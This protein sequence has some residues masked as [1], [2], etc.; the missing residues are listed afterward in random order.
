MKVS[1]IVPI[2]NTEKY[3]DQCIESIVSQEYA[4]LEILLINDGSTDRSGNI[5]RKWEALDARVRYVEKEN[6]GQG[7]ARNLG[8]RLAAGEYIIFVD[9]DDY[10][11]REL[12][13]RVL[14]RITE[15][16][17]DIC[18]YASNG[19]GD[20]VSK[21]MLEY[22]LVE[23][24]CVK[25][26]KELLGR[27]TPILWDKMFSTAFL[28]NAD[29]AMSN[30]IC[31]DLVYNARLC[32][33]A[34]KICFLDSPLYNYRYLRE[35]NFSTNYQ[36]YFEVEES[37][38][39]LNEIFQREGNFEEYWLQ[40]Y[41]I[42]FTMFKDILFRIRVKKEYHAPAEIK[43]RYPNFF[44][45]YK[46]FLSR[47]F[48]RYLTMEFQEKNFLLAG[49]YSLRVIVH[50]MLLD[51]EFL[52]A[53]YAAGSLVSMMSDSYEEAAFGEAIDSKVSA[54]LEGIS[55]GGV[56]FK[57]AYRKRCVEQD[58]KKHFR[59]DAK[60]EEMDYAAVDLL[61]EISDLIKL[62]EGCYITDSAFLREA[63]ADALEG[64][65]RIPF[66]SLERRR[67]FQKYAPLFAEKVRKAKIPVIVVENYLC[68]KHSGYYDQFTEYDAIEWIWAANRELEWCYG[69]LR[70]CL[71]E[72]LWADAS[73]FR[74]LMFTHDDFPFGMEPV[75][76]NSSYYQRMAVRVN[77]AV[78]EGQEAVML[79]TLE[80]DIEKYDRIFLIR[81]DEPLKEKLLEAFLASQ[82]ARETKWKVLVLADGEN[83]YAM[84]GGVEYRQI[85]KEYARRLLSL[86]HMYEFSDRFRLISTVEACGNLFHF[87][88]AGLLDAE[89][90]WEA[91]LC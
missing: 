53:D 31:E 88:E 48:S 2:Y 5:C 23:G 82:A 72:A 79:K 87:A 71:P 6:E 7:I 68:E 58:V 28:R 16:K 73:E 56:K 40:L 9:S 86:Y 38:R 69:Y 18:V 76:Y 14:N 91:L 62:R 47:W 26:N 78:R 54:F 50:S 21:G 10:I 4:D 51:E 89:E 43:S 20:K 37:I 45:S 11:E 65:E 75:Y 8:I 25:E 27:Q 67:L 30:R 22:K 74:E 81:E 63:G 33:Q 39:E 80:S 41:E 83:K 55:S 52:R 12:V 44:R 32:I 49:S 19:I 29:I 57:N 77:Q 34:G 35:G 60:L 1:V 46:S 13:G 3:L 90:V 42:S 61:E 66:L 70:Q 59:R 15:E 24:S 64:C 85:T 36:R 17:A 84:G